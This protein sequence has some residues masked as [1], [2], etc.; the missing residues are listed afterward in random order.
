MASGWLHGD[1]SEGECGMRLDWQHVADAAQALTDC[2][3]NAHHVTIGDLALE[4]LAT[5]ALEDACRLEQQ[6][7]RLAAAGA[8]RQGAAKG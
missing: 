7:R 5:D 4:A 1:A 6:C 3:R 2:L 8:Q